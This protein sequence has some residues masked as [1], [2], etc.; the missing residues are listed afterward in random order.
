MTTEKDLPIRI[1]DLHDGILPASLPIPVKDCLGRR[2]S[3]VRIPPPRS[4]ASVTYGV[5]MTSLAAVAVASL[6]LGACG[7]G[8]A[9]GPS[10]VVDA[11]PP[12]AVTPAAAG[13]RPF[14]A[15]LDPA[16]VRAVAVVSAAG[17]PKRW[18]GGPFRHCFDANVADRRAM[19]EAV[20]D[21]MSALS[22]IPRAA[23]G[24]CNVTWK[25]A[26]D[27]YIEVP[28]G[29]AN[30]RLFGTETAIYSA[31]VTFRF[32]DFV[33]PA[34]ALH[35]GGHVLGLNHSPRPADLMNIASPVPDFSADEVAVLAWIYPSTK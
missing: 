28:V 6:L 13:P 33:L 20:A 24:A 29:S 18:E 35:E 11:P 16:Y 4:Y 14:P 10:A 21:R 32:P 1:N 17:V 26:A 25:V 2:W 9:A 19:L 7:G 31:V 15:G 23:A 27:P 34:A 3:R 8:T 12:A 5:R 22:G 30:S